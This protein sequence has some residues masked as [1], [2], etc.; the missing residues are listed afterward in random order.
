MD[1]VPRFSGLEEASE[2]FP[3]IDHE[4]TALGRLLEL[5]NDDVRFFRELHEQLGGFEQPVVVPA[6][7]GASGLIH[8]Q[9]VFMNLRLFDP[10]RFERGLLDVP[11]VEVGL[12]RERHG[13][14]GDAFVDERLDVVGEDG[15]GRK[16]MFD[17]TLAR[18]LLSA[19]GSRSGREFAVS[20][21]GVD[22]SDGGHGCGS[23]LEVVGGK[24]FHRAPSRGGD[25]V[26]CFFS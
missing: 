3:A 12:G 21:V 16:S 10:D 25:A 11:L 6:F 20:A 13:E 23:R 1:V 7:L 14:A 5:A 19:L 4:L 24:R 18:F 22:L 9:G 17:S 2:R 15:L 8:H 26:F